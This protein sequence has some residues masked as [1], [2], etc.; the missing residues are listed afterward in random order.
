MGLSLC[1]VPDPA[2]KILPTVV[3][4]I[5]DVTEKRGKITR[6]VR[7]SSLPLV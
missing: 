3:T 4:L 2:L 1:I 5:T 7:A 6:I